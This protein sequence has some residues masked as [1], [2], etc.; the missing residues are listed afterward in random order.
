MIAA[1]LTEADNIEK[2][3]RHFLTKNDSGKFIINVVN[4]LIIPLM[5]A[6]FEYEGWDV[7]YGYKDEQEWLYF[8]KPLLGY[9][10]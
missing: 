1:I 3:I 2:N 6:T 10:P 4:Y 7:N 8:D 5:I 9:H